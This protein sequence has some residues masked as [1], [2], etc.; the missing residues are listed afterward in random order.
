MA[1]L[2]GVGMVVMP[3]Q[4]GAV[5]SIAIPHDLKNSQNSNQGDI[6]IHE[7]RTYTLHPGQLERY[8]E[9]AETVVQPIRQ[10]RYG[11]LVGFWYSEFGSLHQVHHV[12]EYPSLDR[13]QADRKDLFERSDWMNEF[14]AHAWP[15]MQIQEVRFMIPAQP[16]NEVAGTHQ[17]YEARIYRTVVGKFK[18]GVEAVR[19]RPLAAGATRVGLWR[20]ETPQPNEV[21]EIV[22]Y[23]SFEARLADASQQKEQQGWWREFGPMFVAT[24]ATLML[25]IGISP[26]K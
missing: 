20:C 21:C 19:A 3:P 8:L 9:L 11:R 14:I 23:P 26:V 2:P 13:R 5:I 25:P 22:A 12:W 15:T 24:N 17:L 1:A 16:Y 7:Y 6:V 4:H 10:D 18:E